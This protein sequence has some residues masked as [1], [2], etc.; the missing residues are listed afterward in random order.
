MLIR[1]NLTTYIFSASS[2]SDTHVNHKKPKKVIL[3]IR[4]NSKLS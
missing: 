3:S 1:G 4:K 2:K